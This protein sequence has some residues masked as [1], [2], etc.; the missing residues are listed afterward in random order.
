MNRINQ[1][2]IANLITERKL[3]SGNQY[4]FT[5]RTTDDYTKEKILDLLDE[6]TRVQPVVA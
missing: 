3:L 6:L 1:S 2:E 5:I 4:E